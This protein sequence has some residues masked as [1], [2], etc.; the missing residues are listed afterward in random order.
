MNIDDLLDRYEESRDRGTPVTPEELCAD[1]PELLAEVQAKIAALERLEGL[2]GGGAPAV[3]LSEAGRYKPVE[4]HARGG[5]G[6]V[7]RARDRELG[8]DVA[9]KRTRRADLDDAFVREA[10]ITGRLEHPGIVPV[11]GLGRDESGHPFYAMRLVGGETFD[12]AIAR[13]ADRRSLLRRFLTVCETVAYAHSR[14]VIHRDLKPRNILLGA[15]GE[16][17]LVDWGLAK[18]VDES[19]STE[20]GPARAGALPERRRD[21]D[22]SPPEGRAAVDAAALQDVEPTV[23]GTRKG[24]PAYM[25]P[26]QARGDPVGPATDLFALGATLR[27]ILVGD[28]HGDLKPAPRALGAVCKKAMAEQP[29]AR[30]ANA[31]ALARDIERWLA[32]EPVSAWREPLRVRLR[33]WLRRHRTLV[34]TGAAML[35]VAAVAGVLLAWREREAGRREANRRHEAEQAN[36][37]AAVFAAQYALELVRPDA[38]RV[39]LDGVPP[40][41][42]SFEWHVLN[43]RAR[44]E[45]LRIR[46]PIR[47]DKDRATSSFLQVRPRFFRTTTLPGPWRVLRGS[48]FHFADNRVLDL[49]GLRTGGP[50]QKKFA[51]GE[52]TDTST[53]TGLK[54]RHDPAAAA[55]VTPKTI[56]ASVRS[57][58]GTRIAVAGAERQVTVYERGTKKV[59][60][61][62]VAPT[63]PRGL[64]FSRNGNML[65]MLVKGGVFVQLLSK[66]MTLPGWA[67]Q[68]EFS[69][70]A[71]DDDGTRLAVT[72]RA[73]Y[74]V[75][76]LSTGGGF[77]NILTRFGDEAT[78]LAFVGEERLAVG[79]IDGLVRVHD[80]KT[81]ASFELIAHEGRVSRLHA[82]ANY[83]V[84]ESLLEIKAWDARHGDGTRLLEAHPSDPVNAV[85]VIGPW[86]ASGGDDLC[87]W[88]G[89]KLV[90]RFT[91]DRKVVALCADGTRFA[92]A[93]KSQ[94]FTLDPKTATRTTL[95]DFKNE[96]IRAMEVK[97][98]EIRVLLENGMDHAI[99]VIGG[100]RKK[101]RGLVDWTTQLEHG[102]VVTDDDQLTLHGRPLDVRNAELAAIGRRRIAVSFRDD[103]DRGYIAV[104]DFEGNK[105]LEFKAHNRRVTA[106]AFAGDRLVTGTRTGALGIWEGVPQH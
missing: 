89:R 4:L 71:L 88:R 34:A 37:R 98:G 31:Q 106:L 65:G 92:G 42:R 23:Y 104:F 25:S 21:G 93:T 8:R 46:A 90:K 2:L 30:Y 58:D 17:V 54:P 61:S 83:I 44:G 99:A 1:A 69:R 29:T 63:Q 74:Q 96:D 75:L 18:P 24:T 64:T 66:T 100:G 10:E 50:V 87:L 16:T 81:K 9:L 57:E 84:S 48:R 15:F 85:A 52:W 55:L 97:D 14:G 39:A 51:I 77:R 59:L 5:I 40:D 45:L 67:L 36:Y 20:T 56:V 13:G 3:D 22:V 60:W 78:A 86:I 101:V 26:E 80:L 6:D 32:D 19:D 79:T 62:G 11:Y 103:R 47:N 12:E 41:A 82:N 105:V 72:G 73:G 70:I 76:F 91:T 102:F 33:R 38:A 35:L 49:A 28:P 7:Y 53:V 43:R 94:V 27:K 68:G 95:A